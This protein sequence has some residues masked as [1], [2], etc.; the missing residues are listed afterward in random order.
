MHPSIR[1]GR[2]ALP[3]LGQVS[4]I[5]IVTALRNLLLVCVPIGLLNTYNFVRHSQEIK[6]FILL[7]GTIIVLLLGQAALRWL[8][9]RLLRNLARKFDQS[10]RHRPEF[11][12]LTDVHQR[13][14]NIAR[15]KHFITGTGFA[16]LLDLPWVLAFF[17]ILAGISPWLGAASLMFSIVISIVAG[18][19]QHHRQ[20]FERNFPAEPN[21]SG[22]PDSYKAFI[23]ATA[24]NRLSRENRDKALAS[25]LNVTRLGDFL[26]ATLLALR[27][28][29]TM[30][31]L[32]IVTYLSATH[33]GSVSV[34]VVTAFLAN[35]ISDSLETFVTSITDISSARNSWQTIASANVLPAAVTPST[36]SKTF[37]L[38]LSHLSI[39]HP[40]A[41]ALILSDVTLEL[42]VGDILMIAADNGAGKTLVANTLAGCRAPHAGQILFDGTDRERLAEGYIIETVGYVPQEINFFPATI[43]DNISR[44]SR[45]IDTIA[46]ERALHT[47]GLQPFIAKLESGVD[48]RLSDTFGPLSIG[49]RQRLG[50]ARAIYNTPHLLILDEPFSSLD[51]AGCEMLVNTLR[52]HQLSGGI[53]IIL[54]AKAITLPLTSKTGSIKDG[55]IEIANQTETLADS[56]TNLQ[57]ERR[58]ELA[59][60]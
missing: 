44:F 55:K 2:E 60:P 41:D 37:D 35:R 4:L 9:V 51:N 26:R 18:A 27:S 38:R 36:S 10:Y 22:K 21:F 30:T 20:Q 7:F 47:V 57:S 31:L 11:Q 59:R 17:A 23:T 53:A 33:S 29:H 49:I 15:V 12:K 46:V 13:A 42:T 58:I 24:T 14:R 25:R 52:Q 32:G 48:T 45:T 40:N 50:I 39:A 5:V 19:E 56:G 16:S 3:L 34:V 8:R 43:A 28:V 6:Y 54:V 1:S